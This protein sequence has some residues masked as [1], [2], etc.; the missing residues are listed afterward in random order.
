MS[1]WGWPITAPVEPQLALPWVFFGG[2]GQDGEG[3]SGSELCLA[4]EQGTFAPEP[5]PQGRLPAEK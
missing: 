4:D 1:P 5:P 2:E 3:T